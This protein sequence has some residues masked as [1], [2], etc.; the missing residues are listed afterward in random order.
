MRAVLKTLVQ[1]HRK[2]ILHRDIKPG[3]F[4]LLDESPKAPLKV[5]G[6]V[7]AFE[8]RCAAPHACVLCQPESEHCCAGT[9]SPCVTHTCNS[10]HLVIAGCAVSCEPW[11][12]PWSKTLD[13]SGL[14]RY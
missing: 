14:T 13:R 10:L 4:M 5:I 3:N 1:C 7:R 8:R 2:G 6:T 9:S 11:S 12:D